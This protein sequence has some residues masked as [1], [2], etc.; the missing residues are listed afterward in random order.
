MNLISYENHES[1][2]Q[3][4]INFTRTSFN[5]SHPSPFGASIYDI[6]SGNLFAQAYD[7]VIRTS[8]PT[9]HAEMNVIR[10]A[11]KKLNSLSLQGYIL[12]STCEPCPMC[13]SACIWA[14]LDSVVYGAST[15]EDANK[16]WPQPSD[17]THHELVKHTLS[18]NKC[19][20]ISNVKRNLCQKLFIN[21]NA[22]Y[23]KNHLQLP[24]NR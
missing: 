5:T 13:M 22:L 1:R 7:T 23:E 14:E 4:L 3:E 24:P 2:M 12:Y 21:C 10:I 6:K 8:D 15:I 16:Y 11:T 19:Q 9:N 20:V 18:K 17:I